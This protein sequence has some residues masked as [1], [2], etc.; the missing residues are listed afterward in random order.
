MLWFTDV[1]K[2]IVPSG[3]ACTEAAVARLQPGTSSAT[4]SRIVGKRCDIL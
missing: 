1:A 2:V 4:S 3:D